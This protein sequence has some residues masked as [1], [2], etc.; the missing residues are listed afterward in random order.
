[1][2]IALAYGKSGVTLDVPDWVQLDQFGSRAAEHKA[3]YN[4][5]VDELSRWGEANSTPVTNH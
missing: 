3:G 2:E 1:M 4:D 5:F